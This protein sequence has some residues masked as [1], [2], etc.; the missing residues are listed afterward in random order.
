LKN[1]ANE[2]YSST[3]LTI[4]PA[5]LTILQLFPKYLLYNKNMKKIILCLIGLVFLVSACEQEKIIIDSDTRADTSIS[6]VGTDKT[7]GDQ[8]HI[9]NPSYDFYI[10]VEGMNPWKIQF[11][12]IDGGQEEVAIGVYKESPHHKVMAKRVFLYNIDY[13]RQRLSPKIRIS[14]LS[15]PLEDFIMADLDQE[16][17]DSIISLERLK[18]GSSQLAAYKWTNF[19]FDRSYSSQSFQA[20]LIFLDKE[21]LIKIDEQEAQLYVEG[22]KILWQ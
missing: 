13:E 18:D 4:E 1:S 6:I 16:G 22:G 9:K 21:A 19:S 15:N 3:L 8:I 17:R 7:Y 14:R 2:I 11:C 10:D 5:F 12:N 20:E